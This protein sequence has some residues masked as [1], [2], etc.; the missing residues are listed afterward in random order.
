MMEER[1]YSPRRFA[2]GAI[3][4]P[5]CRA[6]LERD[7]KWCPACGFTGS[8]TLD[9]FGDDP[10]PLL[11]ILDV[12]NIWSEKDQREIKAEI[13]RFNVR[14]PQIRWRVCGV[15][16]GGEISL[17]LFGFWLLNASPLAAEETADDRSWTVLLIVDADTRR[18]SVTAGYRAEVWLSDDMWEK[19]LA[20]TREPFRAGKPGM[21]ISSFMKTTHV[22]FDKAWNRCR[23]QL[24]P[25][26]R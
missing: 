24:S 21:A 15:A 14:Y 6:M 11:P 22:L 4:C 2:I 8:K 12:A 17:P 19:A 5:A 9:M 20:E 16:L 1:E 23:K 3:T 18:A 7:A 10:P 25:Q 26:L 13:A